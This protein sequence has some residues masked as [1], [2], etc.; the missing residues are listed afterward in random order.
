M[1]R[2]LE[3]T[4]DIQ[5]GDLRTVEIYGEEIRGHIRYTVRRSEDS[6]DIQ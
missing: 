4:L 6:G 1:V 2:R 5:L 3:D